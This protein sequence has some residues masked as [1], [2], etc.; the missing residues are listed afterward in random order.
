MY[1]NI[2]FGYHLT[3]AKIVRKMEEDKPVF[4]SIGY[5]TCHWCHVMAHESFE[6][7]EIA[8][9]LNQ[10]FISI[11]VDKEERP[12]IDSIYMSVFQAITG[13]GRWPTTI[14]MTPDQKPFFAGTYFPRTARYGRMGLKELLLVVHQKW[15]NSRETLLESADE[16]VAYLE[17][18][19]SPA[20]EAGTE[21]LD[22][23][24]KL[25]QQTFDEE[26][27]GF[28]DAPKFPAAHNLLFLLKYYEKRKD[29]SVLEI[30]EKTGNAFNQYFGITR[31][32]N[33]EG[34]NIPN[35]LHHG[36]ET[37]SFSAFDGY[38]PV[39]YAYRRNRYALQLDNRYLV[40]ARQLCDKVLADFYDER[41]G[42]F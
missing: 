15:E 30:V 1:I 10:Y 16:V 34:K 37:E 14:F 2:Y 19:A 33:F 41:Q 13:S 42:G 18:E 3:I 23:E 38:L 27:G 31:D 36:Q 32:G 5:S 35:L 24:V 11:K 28:G 4:L 29:K 17:K 12:D 26:F 7:S 21:W 22:S 8:E 40:R 6:N 20:A 9:I 39:V 25:Y